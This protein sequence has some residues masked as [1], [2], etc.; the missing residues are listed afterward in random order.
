MIVFETMQEEAIK[1]LSPLSPCPIEASRLLM[2]GGTV[3]EAGAY[4]VPLSAG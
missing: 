3:L 1:I 2:E 4:W